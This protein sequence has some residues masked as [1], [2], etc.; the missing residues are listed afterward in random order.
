MQPTKPQS[1]RVES[2]DNLRVVA[3][4]TVLLGHA[5]HAL[6]ETRAFA[7]V[8]LA[9]YKQGLGPLVFLAIAGFVAV[10]SAHRDFGSPGAGPRYLGK[11]LLRVVPL[12]WVYTALFL[13]V[14]VA[15]P[16]VLDHG[17]LAPGHVLGSFAFWPVP[18]PGDGKLRPLLNSGWALNYVVWFHVWFALC[19]GLGRRAGLALC[20]AGLVGVDWLL[21]GKASGA[22]SFFAS[23]K[24]AV[25]GLGVLCALAHRALRDRLALPFW[26]ALLAVIGLCFF[27]WS[28]G[29]PSGDWPMIGCAI[30]IVMVGA[31]ARRL[32]QGT[33]FAWLWSSL[34]RASYSIYLSQAFTLSAFTVVADRI[35]ALA[36]VPIALALVALLAWSLAWG[37]AG[38]RWLEA[39]LHRC[40][41][42]WWGRVASPAAAESGSTEKRA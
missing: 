3:A 39:P 38:H 35:G 8:E 29:D 7:D 19:L 31:F 17:G 27:A 2:V 5:V 4:L 24:F 28:V 15:I 33:G 40:L 20:V 26:P 23:R 1:K 12:Y 32:R 11:R 36:H 41:V 9:H 21:A 37:V 25:L 42:A 30:A 6:G 13:L 18:R 16:S 34:A 14:A 22:W 10:H